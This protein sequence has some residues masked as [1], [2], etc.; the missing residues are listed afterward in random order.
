MFP[1]PKLVVFS[2]SRS[3]R[4]TVLAE[5]THRKLK[6]GRR[7]RISVPYIHSFWVTR[8]FIVIPESPLHYQPLD[9][10]L[11]GVALGGMTWDHSAPA[12]LH[13]IS[14]IPDI[15]HV[16]TIPTDPFYTFHVGNA[17]DYADE[18]GKSVV[19][20][21]CCAFSDGDIL[22]QLHSFGNP[23][24]K[25]Q[26]HKDIHP[27]PES[28]TK[29]RGI[30]MPPIRQPSFGD[31]RRYRLTLSTEQTCSYD[32][33]ATNI[34]F[35]RFS[36]KVSQ[37]PYKYAWGCQLRSATREGTE[38][39][40]LVKIDLDTGETLKFDRSNFTCSEPIFVPSSVTSRED[41]GCLLSFV[42]VV[43]DVDPRKDRCALLVLDAHTMEQVA[44]CDIG[45][46]KATTFHGSFVDNRY[47]DVSIN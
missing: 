28:T 25:A 2:I 33:I 7:T 15:G 10:L 46:F 43:D 5:I 4:T 35:L 38:R 17:W 36:Q 13:V 42:N 32:T 18:N 6:D 39:Y 44:F 8:R 9:F 27:P 23:R 31:L 3:G 40:S 37:L 30:S 11:R 47:E 21:D 41:E 22:Y 19:V 45:P 34:D 20:M 12:Y 26:V 24:R 29:P 16:T 1:I 14:R